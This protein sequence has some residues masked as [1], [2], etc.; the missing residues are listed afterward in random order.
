MDLEWPYRH[1]AQGL[2]VAMVIGCLFNSFLLNFSEKW[3]YIYLAAL[4]CAGPVFKKEQIHDVPKISV[5]AK[6]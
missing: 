4:S 5:E 2:V 6:L 3:F 1:A